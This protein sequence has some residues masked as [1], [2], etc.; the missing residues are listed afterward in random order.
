MANDNA[1]GF[2]NPSYGAC[3]PWINKKTVG[4]WPSPTWGNPPI[5]IVVAI[6]TSTYKTKTTLQSSSGADPWAR[7][8]VPIN[9]FFTVFTVPQTPK[10]I[11]MQ[12]A[13]DLQFDLSPEDVT[14]NSVG[15]DG[16]DALTLIVP[17][18]WGVLDT[19]VEVKIYDT[20]VFLANSIKVG[21]TSTP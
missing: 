3:L 5:T 4:V 11:Q 8:E 9:T 17:S 1:D 6:L 19:P 2:V 15:A 14:Y 20:P 16:A 18:F 21:L 10:L 12:N 13:S 7:T